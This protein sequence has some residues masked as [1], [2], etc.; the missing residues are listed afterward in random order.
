MKL[1]AC[2]LAA[3]ALAACS[4]KTGDASAGACAGAA[5]PT[6]ENV[7]FVPFAPNFVGYRGWSSSPAAGLASTSPHRVAKAT[8][9]IN[10]KPPAGAT[11][12]PLGTVIVKELESGPVDERVVFAM[13]KRGGDYNPTGAKGWEWFE[14]KN[15]C[16]GNDVQ[17]VWRGV[18]P[19]AGG[20][21][22]AGDANG[23]CNLCHGDA[24]D[25]DFVWSTAL[26]LHR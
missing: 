10:R 23:D 20:D 9:Y 3:A 1:L 13:V 22:Y 15:T 8:V 14:L 16:E 17:I 2:A 24:K 26:S 11:E 4:A 21:K 6:P 19:P 7:S 25:N 12:F 5:S 18:G